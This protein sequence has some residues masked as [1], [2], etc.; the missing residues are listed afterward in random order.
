MIMNLSSGSLVLLLLA[1]RS[2]SAEARDALVKAGGSG[3][4]K[5][6]A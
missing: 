2:K 5:E 4:D 6:F 1:L 3:R